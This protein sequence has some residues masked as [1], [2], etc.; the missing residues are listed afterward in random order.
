MRNLSQTIEAVSGTRLQNQACAVEPEYVLICLFSLS[1]T[2][3]YGF[4][5]VFCTFFS[6]VCVSVYACNASSEV[7]KTQK[8]NFMIPFLSLVILYM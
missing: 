2:I 7:H 6:C 4:D 3:A 5:F 1:G 8:D